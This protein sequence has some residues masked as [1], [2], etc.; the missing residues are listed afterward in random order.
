MCVYV[1]VCVR[2]YILYNYIDFI[3][4]YRIYRILLIIILIYKIY[5]LYYIILHNRYRCCNIQCV[6][7]NYTIYKF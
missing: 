3:E 5:I 1:F 4:F 2:M 7:F 6:Y